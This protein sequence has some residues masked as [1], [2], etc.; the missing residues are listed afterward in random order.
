MQASGVFKRWI[1][2]LDLW[3]PDFNILHNF[4]TLPNLDN[5]FSGSARRTVRC[6]PQLATFIEHH[7]AYKRMASGP[8]PEPAL[9][10]LLRACFVSEEKI[11]QG[12]F[13]PYNLLCSG[14]LVIDLAFMRAVV[15]ASKWLGPHA[16]PAGYISEWPP[17][18]EQE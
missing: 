1:T 2:I 7:T 9:R 11:F 4:G 16:F 8:E 13:S 17:S 18:Q 10:H 3:E 12:P 5:K 6:S 15:A 14:N